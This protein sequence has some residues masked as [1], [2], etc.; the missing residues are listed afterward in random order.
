MLCCGEAFFSGLHKHCFPGRTAWGV[1]KSRASPTPLHTH[2]HTHTHT[3]QRGSGSRLKAT[4]L[5]VSFHHCF[6]DSA[7]QD[8]PSPPS[9]L[10]LCVPDFS[11]GGQTGRLFLEPATNSSH[12]NQLFQGELTTED[13][14]WEAE[15]P[16]VAPGSQAPGINRVIERGLDW[17]CSQLGP[18]FFSP[19]PKFIEA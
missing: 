3:Q 12:R 19:H 9:S 15:D 16:G 7:H 14:L 18:L 13:S 6:Q 5:G 17:L 11:S 2:T 4:P 8:H 10:P 1:G